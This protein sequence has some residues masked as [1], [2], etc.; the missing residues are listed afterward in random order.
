MNPIK[1]GLLESW[2]ECNKSPLGG[3]ISHTL[4]INI[5]R[6]SIQDSERCEEM[7]SEEKIKWK[8]NKFSNVECHHCSLPIKKRNQIRKKID[9]NRENNNDGSK[10]SY[11]L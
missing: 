10:I 7:K 9:K 8:S 11:C 2:S 5:L 1:I 3:R 6:K 4:P